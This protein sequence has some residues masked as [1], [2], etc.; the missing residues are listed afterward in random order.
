MASF[1][2]R[3]TAQLGHGAPFCLETLGTW[4]DLVY[5]AKSKFAELNQ[6][7]WWQFQGVVPGAK[8]TYLQV[9]ACTLLL[10]ME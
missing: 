2:V 1:G 10:K 8:A 6:G 5:E 9:Q 4:V 7:L 3:L